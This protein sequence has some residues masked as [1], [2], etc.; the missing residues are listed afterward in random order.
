[1]LGAAPAGYFL[2]PWIR[3]NS[4]SAVYA[5]DGGR[6]TLL[7]VTRQLVGCAWAGI[8]WFPYV[9][10]VGPLPLATRL[11]RTYERIGA[12]LAERWD[13][14]G[15]FGVDTVL[16][17]REVWTI[18]VNPR[19]R[20]RWKCG[21]GNG[22]AAVACHRDGMP[23]RD[24]IPQDRCLVAR[25]HGGKGDHQRAASTWFSIVAACDAHCGLRRLPNRHGSGVLADLP[26][27]RA[28]DPPAGA[29]V[30]TVLCLPKAGDYSAHVPPV[31][32]ARA[33]QLRATLTRR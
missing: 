7:C 28:A 32:R 24:A 3:G 21:S 12:Q 13:L 1:M 26:R 27:V 2:Q 18:E 25:R 6:A 15:L 33:G 16:S 10:S 31:A 11:R 20:P 9:G 22:A 29:P 19:Y 30:F 14:R 8:A 17:G 5:A 4:L 23:G